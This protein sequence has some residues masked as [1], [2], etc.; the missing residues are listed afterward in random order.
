MA[1]FRTRQKQK[2][3]GIP[4]DRYFLP[5]STLSFPSDLLV[6]R[7]T[8]PATPFA[9]ERCP[10]CP[11]IG[12]DARSMAHQ[13]AYGQSYRQLSP[14]NSISYTCTYLYVPVQ[15]SFLNLDW[16]TK[17]WS[18]AARIVYVFFVASILFAR[19]LK[20]HLQ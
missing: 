5:P 10:G 16:P 3:K 18:R 9:V 15:A 7:Y 19:I 2:W 6:I 11:F 17:F 13:P 20:Q 1:I 8:P 14:P 4:V 12:R